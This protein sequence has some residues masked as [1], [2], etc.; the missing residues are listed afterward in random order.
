[1]YEY[2][3]SFWLLCTNVFYFFAAFA[4]S[5]ILAT[6]WPPNYEFPSTKLWQ[7]YAFTIASIPWL[8]L[9]AKATYSDPAPFPHLSQ[10]CKEKPQGVLSA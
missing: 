10:I 2:E 4:F 3:I 7:Q 9:G 8:A 5:N 1:M 6:A